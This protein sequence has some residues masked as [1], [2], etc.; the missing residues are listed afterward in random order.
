MDNHEFVSN[1]STFFDMENVCIG[2]DTGIFIFYVCFSFCSEMKRGVN[3]IC[4]RMCFINRKT[5]LLGQF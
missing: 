4:F 5:A 2:I 3:E 1:V